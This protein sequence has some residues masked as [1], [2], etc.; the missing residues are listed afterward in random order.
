MKRFEL[1]YRVVADGAP[2]FYK[3]CEKVFATF[4]DEWARDLDAHLERLF[5]CDEEAYRKAVQGYAKFSLS[6]MRLQARFNKTRRYEEQSYEDACRNVYQNRQFMAEVYLP[7]IFV[8]QF[9]WQHHYRQIQFHRERFLPLLEGAADRRFYDVGTGTGFY[10][11]QALQRLPGFHGYGIDTS[12][13]A[14]EFTER[15]VKAWGFGGAYT[16]MDVDITTAELEPVS[17]VQSIEVLEHLADPEEF[18]RHLRKMLR[19][20]GYGFIAAAITAPEDDHIY[21][22]WTPE[23]VIRQLNAAG[24]EV[25]EHREEAGYEGRPGEIIPKVSAFIVR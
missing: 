5:G 8:S 18:L 22:Y 25:L 20:G 1:F 23:D 13:H 19:P 10:S 2:L 11:V 24:F 17:C 12:P 9:L 3:N 16:P 14:R 15:H 6:A 7:G 21:L 4:G